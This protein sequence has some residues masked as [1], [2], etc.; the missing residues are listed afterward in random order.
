MNSS[1]PSQW[2]QR[3]IV[4]F[5]DLRAQYAVLREEIAPAVEAV[6]KQAAFILGPDVAAF[7]SEFADFIGVSHGVGVDS[8][9]AALKV[10]LEALGI[11][12]GDEVIIPANTYIACAFAVSQVGATPVLVDMRDDYLIDADLIEE[13]ITPRTKAL[14]PVHLYGQA[15]DMQVILEIARRRHLKVIEDA[16]QAHGARYR[17]RPCGSYGDVGCFSLYPGKNLGAYGDA[18]IVV[19]N[20]AAIADRLK[21]LRDF[22]Q[23]KKYEHLIIGDNC[24]LDTVQAAILRVKLRHL[25]RW[26]SQRLS[27]AKMYDARLEGI[28]LTPPPRRNDEG[29]VYHLYVVQVPERDRAIERFAAAGVQTGI[30][31]PIPIHR[32]PAYSG[33]N[34][35]AGSYPRTEQAAEKILSL[36][37][38]PEITEAQIDRVVHA[39]QEHL[40]EART[41]SPR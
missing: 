21:L 23:R 5:V 8:G 36:P 15:V 41:G 32:Q 27:A 7:E 11:G 1:K 9:T 38:F 31:Y 34:L 25:G 22:G 19:T 10:A 2:T 40:S 13:A 29:H 37:M 39:L 6:F 12:A 16:S 17:G 26:N 24:R 3:E 14:M 35:P 30:H 18:G 4:P 20:D 33:L 28:G